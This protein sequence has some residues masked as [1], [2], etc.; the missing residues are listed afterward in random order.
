MPRILEGL[1]EHE[2]R[3]AMSAMAALAAESDA[4]GA[5]VER[6]LE[7]LPRL[8]A[9][10]LTTLS[11][12]DLG[13]GTR[14]VFGRQAEMLSDADRAAFD[15]HFRD[16]PLVRFHSSHPGGPTQRISDCMT[17]SQFQRLPVYSDYYRRIGIKHVMALPLRIDSGNVIS[18]VFNRSTS[19]F[20]SAERAVLDAI[21][22][23]L[24]ALY[25]NL[26][27]REAAGVGFDCLSN[28]VA[29]AGWS[30]VRVTLGGRMLDA[31]APALQ[32]LQRFFPGFASGYGVH[33][34][35]PLA[36]WLARCG[37]LEL[38]GAAARAT[39]CFTLARGG[40][41]LEAH[42]VADPVRPECGYLI[43]KCERQRVDAQQ[44]AALPLTRRERE[45]MALVAAG[46][47]NAEI[48]RIID[49]SARTVQKHLEHIFQKLGVETRTAA[50]IK[51]MIAAEEQIAGTA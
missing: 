4:S 20:K 44:L 28:L 45:V 35:S 19:D 32:L 34:P 10:D 27:A 48:A 40:A 23:P 38:G 3:R 15:H 37:S 24:A 13:R 11:V 18:I 47:T 39:Q 22:L 21:R 17:A 36:T 25:R 2:L 30:V 41:R 12:C 31:S 8:V 43:L 5:F 9:S 49:I 29:R 16:H 14:T 33:L 6:S 42:F 26:A 46:K 51:A 50:A 1:T 7:R